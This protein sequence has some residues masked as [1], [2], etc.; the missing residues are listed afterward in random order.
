MGAERSR[1]KE[2]EK[3]ASLNRLDVLSSNLGGDKAHGVKRP[4]EQCDTAWSEPL[5]SKLLTSRRG[6]NFF[7]FRR[8]GF[9]TRFSIGTLSIYFTVNLLNW[10]VEPSKDGIFPDLWDAKPSGVL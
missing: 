3:P 9:S 8:I 2:V 7:C 5:S 10:S 6:A 1:K 4:V